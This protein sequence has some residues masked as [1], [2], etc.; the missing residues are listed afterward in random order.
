MKGYRNDDEHA[1]EEEL[2]EKTADNDI[3][4][5]LEGLDGTRRLITTA[6]IN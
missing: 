3:R 2:Y 4:S 5:T 1:E 6:L